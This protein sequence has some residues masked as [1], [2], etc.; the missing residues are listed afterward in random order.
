MHNRNLELQVCGHVLMGW[1]QG[2][3]PWS[4]LDASQ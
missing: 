1:R 4:G 3:S 2:N